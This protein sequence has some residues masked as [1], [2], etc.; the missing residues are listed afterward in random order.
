M[1]AQLRVYRRRLRTV[2]STKKI[3]KA[4]ELIAA[5]RIVKAQ[6]RMNNARPYA[7]ELSRALAAL[8][9]DTTLKH[10]MLTGVENP[11]RAGIVVIT[12]DRGLAGGYNANAL[13]VANELASKLEGE[14]KEVDRYVI[15]RK[16]AAFYNFRNI[17]LAGTWTGFSEQP[18]FIDARGATEA[19]VAALSATS[20]GTI[21][22]REGDEEN[23]EEGKPGIDE[24]WVVYTRFV[25]SVTQTATAVQVSPIKDAGDSEHGDSDS[26]SEDDEA[27]TGG[28]LFEF[29]PEPARLIE[30]LLPRYISSRIFSALLESAASESAARRRA[31]KSASDNAT[32]LIKTF[33][34]LANQARQAE[35]T[36]EISEIVGGADALA[37]A[38]EEL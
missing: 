22:S 10:P 35:I 21:T 37:S 28:A 20:E 36:Q 17:A 9:G 30:A 32:D 29:E 5:S 24:L 26:S 33:T 12:S 34:R 27:D 15:G 38:G 4:M 6:Q 31:M 19:V 1:G 13:K 23:P 8:S 11:R 3:T 14:G 16:G 7:K 18:N 2:S 25:N